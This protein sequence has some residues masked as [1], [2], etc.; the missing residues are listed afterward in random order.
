MLLRSKIIQGIFLALFIGGLYFGVGQNDYTQQLLW[1]SITG[2]LFFMTITSM[3]AFL[4][5]MTLTFPM[6]R[7]VFFKEQD[8][9]M[10]N[11]GQYFLARNLI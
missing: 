8:S 7:D 9:K 5:P 11:I 10:Y 1:N 6:E 2:F 4:S 3:M